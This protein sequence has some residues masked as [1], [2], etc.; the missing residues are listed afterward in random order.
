MGDYASCYGGPPAPDDPWPLF[1]SLATKVVGRFEAR[2]RLLTADAVAEAI[3]RAFGD[4]G[5]AAGRRDRALKAAYPLK[6]PEPRW[7]E[8]MA[9]QLG[10]VPE[11]EADGPA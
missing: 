9:A 8:N 3:A 5:E 4:S 6:N 2:V 7:I 10:M 11:P 1:L